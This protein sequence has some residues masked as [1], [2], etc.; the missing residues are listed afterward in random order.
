MYTC[1]VGFVSENEREDRKNKNVRITNNGTN[2][3]Q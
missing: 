3:W 1:I 2:G